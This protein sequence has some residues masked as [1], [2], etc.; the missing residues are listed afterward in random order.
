MTGR[1]IDYVRGAID[2]ERFDYAFM[3]YSD[4]DEIKDRV[5]H[6]L[7]KAYIKAAKALQEYVG[8]TDE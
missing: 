4:F 5:F 6:R 3:Y 7:R 8:E 1:E 2:N